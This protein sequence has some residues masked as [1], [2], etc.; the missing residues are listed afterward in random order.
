[1]STDEPEGRRFSWPVSPVN[2][3]LVVVSVVAAIGCFIAGN[4]IGGIAL[5]IAGVAA[6]AG[7]IAARRGSAGDLERVNALEYADERDRQAGIKG[8]AAVG[9]AALVL[10]AAQLFVLT[11]IDVEPIARGIALVFFLL[12]T[13]VW[14]F[15][16]WLFVR[17]G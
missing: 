1:M 3:V 14:F 10:G 16:N 6:G 12:L 11:I 9:A 5:L 4:L 8:L 15:A 13:A 17:R 2:T 7:A